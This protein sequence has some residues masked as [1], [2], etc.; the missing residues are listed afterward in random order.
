MCGIAGLLDVSRGTSAADLEAIA[1]AM[2]DTL[3]R[4]GPDDRGAWADAGAGVAL[5]SRRLAIVDLSPLG[6]QP[7]VSACGRFTVAYNGEV[8][9]HRDLRAELERA[10]YDFRG[11]SDTEVLLAAVC[12]WGLDGALARCNGHVRVR[13]VGP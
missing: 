3:H 5:A 1:L 13:A 8:Y 9:N 4:R 10:G 2:A 11:Q 6:H 12:V 7:M